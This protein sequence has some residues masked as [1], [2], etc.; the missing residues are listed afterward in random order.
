MPRC[1]MRSEVS[2]V[3]VYQHMRACTP[4]Y[5]QKF[6][7]RC[8]NEPG[9]KTNLSWIR[10][11]RKVARHGHEKGIEHGETDRFAEDDQCEYEHL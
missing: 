5:T 8:P 6:A 3:D 9:I 1:H 2:S 10:G 7:Y 11:Q 4:Q